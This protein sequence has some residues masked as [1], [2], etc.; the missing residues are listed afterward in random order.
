MELA[1]AADWGDEHHAVVLVFWRI[2]LSVIV[3][4]ASKLTLVA[5]LRLPIPRTPWM[6]G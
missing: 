3:L 6:P 1:L 5:C 4:P 2:L